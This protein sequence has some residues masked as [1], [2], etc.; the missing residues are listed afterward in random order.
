MLGSNPSYRLQQLGSSKL[1]WKAIGRHLGHTQHGTKFAFRRLTSPPKHV[2]KRDSCGWAAAGNFC[3]PLK[4][5]ACLS[6]HLHAVM[7]LQASTLFDY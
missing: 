4:P 6:D 2:G 5:I 3:Q 1:S 7:G